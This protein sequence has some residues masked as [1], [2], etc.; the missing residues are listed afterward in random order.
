MSGRDSILDRVRRA[1]GGADRAAIDA[2]IGRTGANLTPARGSGNAEALRARFTE[3]AEE[4]A[5]TVER[6]EGIDRVPDAV[7]RYLRDRNLPARAAVV[8]GETLGGLDWA[9][10]DRIEAS[11]RTA[12]AAVTP[13]LA[14]VAETGTVLLST[15]PQSPNALHLLPDS[16][17]V[18]LKVEDLVGSYEEALARLRATA[19]D[20][21]RAATF[22][23]GPSRSSDIERK[24]QIG[25]HG[26]L[27][28][29][30]LIVD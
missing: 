15:G 13:A 23:T 24:L 28:L 14:G 10:I 30:I 25:V 5:A 1:T 16:H 3:M 11:N 20:L 18:V 21:P 7:A 26:P 4:V 6:I 27:R 2:R 9:G 17:I 8:E 29:H 12:P 22:V 19:D